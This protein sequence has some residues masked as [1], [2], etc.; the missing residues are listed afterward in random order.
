MPEHISLTENERLAWA[1]WASIPYIGP[2]K[3]ALLRQA[4]PSLADA[5]AATDTEV[6][7]SLQ[8]EGKVTDAILKAKA[9]LVPE[10]NWQRLVDAGIRVITILDHDYPRLL[11]ETH[12]APAVL[13]LRGSLPPANQLLLAVVGTRTCTD[14]GRKATALIVEPLVRAGLGVISGLALGIDGLAHEAALAAGG[15]T[16]AVMGT[17][18]DTV[19]PPQH[20]DLAHRI[21][22]A[23][24]GLLSEFPLQTKPLA[25][26][27]PLRNR[28][29]SGMCLG[30]LV[31]EAG[32]KSGALLTAKLALDENREVF[33]VPGPIT[34]DASNGPHRFIR[35]G[36]TLVRSTEDILAALNVTAP[37]ESEPAAKTP[38]PADNPEEQLVIQHLVAGAKHVDELSRLCDCDPSVTNA[39]LIM[40]ELKGRVRHLGGLTY[41]L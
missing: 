16:W 30:T 18:L 20:R 3:I 36:A 34:S 8:R 32:D 38:P 13:F 21:I 27:F 6:R 1:A 40:L 5:W 41:S 14:Y 26:N 19:Y 11:K 2:K 15:K 31:V 17:G 25:Q 29:V 4:F 23:G 24:G 35:L 33:A 22:E 37:I 7:T 12:D 10:K 39:T 28:I 9:A